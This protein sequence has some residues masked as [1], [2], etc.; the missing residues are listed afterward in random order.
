M[1]DIWGSLYN[2]SKIIRRSQLLLYCDKQIKIYKDLFNIFIKVFKYSQSLKVKYLWQYLYWMFWKFCKDLCNFFSETC[3][4]NIFKAC[5]RYF[6]SIFYFSL[7]DRPSKTMKNVFY[8]I[9]K[10]LFVLEIFKFLYFFPSFPHCPDSK[11]QMEV[12]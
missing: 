4:L 6:L 12:E 10:A 2:P 7:S 11:G 1:K 8:F 5:V 9:L 3:K